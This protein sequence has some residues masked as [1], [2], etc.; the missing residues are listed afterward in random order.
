MLF[1][2]QA[3]LTHAVWHA[4]AGSALQQD[5]GAYERERAPAPELA[6]LCAF[7]TAFGQALG[8]GPAAS[9]LV[10]HDAAV[11]RA[12][13]NCSRTSAAADALTPRS[14]GPPALL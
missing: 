14:R 6:T 9:P 2:Q 8:A 3:A 12:V 13:R 4:A 7:D 5:D 11:S 10:L 1:A